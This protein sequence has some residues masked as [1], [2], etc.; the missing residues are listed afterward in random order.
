MA[1]PPAASAANGG[2]NADLEARLAHLP[3]QLKLKLMGLVVPGANP[4]EN[5]ASY[6]TPSTE[7]LPRVNMRSLIVHPEHLSLWH[8][9]QILALDDPGYFFVDNFMGAAHAEKVRVEGQRLLEFGALRPAQ[10][11]TGNTLW[12]EGALRGDKIMWLN[13]RETYDVMAP[14]TFA[15]IDRMMA[16][17]DELNKVG[18]FA[19][20]HTQV[21]L[22]CY[23][24]GGA[25]CTESRLASVSH[26]RVTSPHTRH[27][28]T[29]HS[30]PPPSPNLIGDTV[31]RTH[32]LQQMCATSTRPR[33]APPVVSRS[34]IMRTLSGCRSTEAV[35]ASICPADPSTS[36]RAAI[37]C[38][39][40]RADCTCHSLC[41]RYDV[42]SSLSDSSTRCCHRTHSASRLR[43]GFTD[44][45]VDQNCVRGAANVNNRQAHARYNT[46]RPASFI[47][48]PFT[49]ERRGSTLYN[50]LGAIAQ[51]RSQTKMC[52]RRCRHAYTGGSCCHV[53]LRFHVSI[54]WCFCQ[55][56]SL[57]SLSVASTRCVYNLPFR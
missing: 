21:Q 29:T 30:S 11:A 3:P 20:D 42:H 41:R 14:S 26:A 45:R 9:K 39:S 50:C 47:L 4:L 33:R 31:S 22:A 10:M 32:S 19:S 55:S 36:S 54:G 49:V 44:R 34:S 18:P 6:E 57:M 13:Q 51:A 56:L 35:S 46:E 52:D 37:A 15:V 7:M 16:M 43:C 2:S 23:D 38:S 28:S 48:W 24:G 12:K 25:R 17:R 1:A 8:E 27:S 5:A 53:P 40:S